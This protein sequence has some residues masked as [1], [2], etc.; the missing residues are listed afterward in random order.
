MEYLSRCTE[1]IDVGDRKAVK[2]KWER[3][4]NVMPRLIDTAVVCVYWCEVTHDKGGRVVRVR[5][6]IEPYHQ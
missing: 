3:G 4:M 1:G 5:G 2:Y 6:G